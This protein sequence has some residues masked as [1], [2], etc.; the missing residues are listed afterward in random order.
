MSELPTFRLHADQLASGAVV[1]SDARCL[2]CEQPRGYVYSG[3]V[4]SVRDDLYDALCPWCVA[5]GSAAARFDASFVDIARDELMALPPEIR[6][7]L[8]HRT[9]SYTGWQE[10]EW[11]AH[12]G[13]AMTFLATVDGDR[14][15]RYPD[16]VAGLRQDFPTWGDTEFEQFV[17]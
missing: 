3:P 9:V 6:D 10:A 16:A 15:R 7:E 13:D 5:D 8:E 12:C 17:G 11:L 2:S 4:F 14:L 1:R